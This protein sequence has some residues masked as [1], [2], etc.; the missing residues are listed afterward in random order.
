MSASA[1][2]FTVTNTADSG[3]GSLRRAILDAN[4]AAGADAVVF[5]PAVFNAPQTITLSPTV[6]TNSA[7]DTPLTITG[8][9]ANLLT[10]TGGT[11]V[12]VLFVNSGDAATAS[13]LTIA[14]GVGDATRVGLVEVYNVP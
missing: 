14:A 8:P 10:V 13:R 3:P 1:A 2:T 9:G 12:C 4:A 7:D 11:A 5:D 6:T